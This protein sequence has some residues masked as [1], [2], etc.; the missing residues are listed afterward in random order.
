MAAFGSSIAS[1]ASAA[2]GSG[3]AEPGNT[4]AAFAAHAGLR[5]DATIAPAQLEQRDNVVL[6]RHLQVVGHRLA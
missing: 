2:A 4:V 1:D 5:L 6:L 3:D